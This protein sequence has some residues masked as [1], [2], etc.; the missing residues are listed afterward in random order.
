MWNRESVNPEE[1]SLRVRDGRSMDIG[2]RRSGPRRSM[3]L[4]V[5]CSLRERREWMPAT[6]RFRAEIFDLSRQGAGLRV[7]AHHGALHCEELKGRFMRIQM[8]M[9]GF[10]RA[11]TVMGEIR[12]CRPGI[13]KET[14]S[15]RM[16][17]QFFDP[18]AE[19]LDAVGEM[20]A[21][22]KGDQQLLWNLW[23]TYAIEQ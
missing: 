1:T 17:V 23:E 7:D 6:P 16:G 20:L 2:D 19:L 3:H 8:A 21:V 9:P 22:G 14:G 12:W 11:L 10:Q 15:V 5:T 13:G 18:P 4:V